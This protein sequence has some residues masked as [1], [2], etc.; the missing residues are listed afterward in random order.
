M[1]NTFTTVQNQPENQ[2]DLPELN[3]EECINYDNILK[4][5]GK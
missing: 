3:I 5:D 1:M 2:F 4:F